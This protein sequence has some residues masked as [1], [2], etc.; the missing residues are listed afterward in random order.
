VPARLAMAAAKAEGEDPR[1]TVVAQA[2]FLR[3]GRALSVE[4][5][6]IGDRVIR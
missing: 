5:G 1:S 4:R 3:H 6:G 2:S